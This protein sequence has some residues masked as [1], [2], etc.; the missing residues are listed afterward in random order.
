MKN[1]DAFGAML[2]R[3]R[4]AADLTLE[5]LAAASGLSD[6]AISDMERG[7]SRGPRVRTI[8]L[9]AD[10]LNLS[11]EDRAA[12]QEAARAG[13]AG[14]QAG[15]A[16]LPMPRRMADFTGRAAELAR[17]AGWADTA[18]AGAPAP[19]IV[20]SGE[21]GVG[22]TSLAIRAAEAWAPD[23]RLFV[24][25]RGLDARPVT[26][27]TVLGRL[28]RAAD[29]SVKAVPRDLDE[30][31]GLWQGLIRGR[32]CVLILDNASGEGQVRRVLPAAGPA[33]VLV[34]SRRTLGGLEGARWTRLDRLPET[35]AV[36][37]LA[38]II[39][40]PRASGDDLYRIARLCA[41][42]PLAL[43]IAGNRL[44]S[45]P[46]WTTADLI[47]RLGS[48][49]RRLDALAAG[50]LRIEA[51]FTLSYRQ[52]SD[53]GQRMF[54]R[55]AL[56]P[57]PSTGP[58]LAAALAGESLPVTEDA[59]D[60]LV[61][62][63]LVQQRTDGRLQL[64]DLLRLYAQTRLDPAE[65]E[66]ATE[67][68]D[69]WLLTR[70]VQAGQYFEP[71]GVPEGF[72]SADEAQAWLTAEVDNWLPV[73]L[74][75]ADDRRVVEV[76]ESLHWFGDA[77]PRWPQWVDVYTASSAAAERLGDRSLQATHLGYLAWAFIIPVHDP[78]R[79]LEP[80]RQ[81]IAAADS[82]GDVRQGGW[83]RYYLSWA[84]HS[85]GRFAEALP[86]GRAGADRLRAAGDR[87]G[88][89]NVL[90]ALGFLLEDTGDADGA[91]A[92]YQ[93]AVEA[94]TD[95]ATAPPRHIAGYIEMSARN[96]LVDLDTAAGRWADAR[97]QLDRTELLLAEFGGFL[98]TRAAETY[99]RRALV[100]AHQGEHAEARAEL[101]RV[102]AVLAEAGQAEPTP[103]AKK[104]IAEVNRLLTGQPSR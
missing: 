32:R 30:A 66:A 62:L 8:E 5:Q 86:V 59:L 17:I 67:R 51:A 31:A 61:D 26:P 46:G 70:T 45:R 15:A 43:R 72:A 18:R 103:S 25:L 16:G 80:A 65:S 85:L 58:E 7:V 99:S 64:H 94:I 2:R 68:R 11:P 91:R 19:V 60:E 63:S 54:R 47:A 29:P 84:L 1:D 20:I 93:E 14:V 12:L 48:E 49:D 24:D 39:D 87:E 76:A 89:P 71:S 40:D 52:L 79:A 78:E 10:G 57:G 55:L 75:T 98:A 82:A 56:V 35:D 4:L 6:R 73:L 88:L 96:S 42:V 92:S 53:V 3:V 90:I 104:R 13:R 83:A 50:D 23:A 97:H 9:L 95:P 34:T 22:K 28:I 33:V 81:A 38:A 77:W 27:A 36:A 69:T 74:E 102:A 100:A 41:R 37:L 44:V 21:P 101:D